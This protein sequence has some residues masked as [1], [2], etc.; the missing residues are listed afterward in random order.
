MG[1]SVSRGEGPVESW[2]PEWKHG[3]AGAWGLCALC[4]GLMSWKI[5]LGILGCENR[6][7]AA[8][9]FAAGRTQN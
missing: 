7:G 3:R 5:Q 8:D 2:A 1:S 9:P 4:S 6:F